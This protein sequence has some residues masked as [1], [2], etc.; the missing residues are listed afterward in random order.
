MTAPV[1]FSVITPTHRRPESLLRMLDG[2]SRQTYPAALFEVIVVGDGHLDEKVRHA[3]FPFRFHAVEQE[4]SGPAAA[5]NHA[6]QLAVEPYALFLDDDVIPDPALVAQHAGSHAEPMNV[7]I[8]PLLP[9]PLVKPAPWTRWEWRTLAEQYRSMRVGEWAPTPRQFY[10]GNASVATEDVRAVGGFNQDF[11][12][13]EDVELAWR[14]HDRG[15]RFVFNEKAA[16]EHLAQRSFKAWLAAAHDY[17]RTD[18]MLERT[19]TG[20]DLPGYVGR[21]FRGRHRFTRALARAVL[22]QPMAWHAVPVAGAAVSRA[23]AAVGLRE[24]SMQ[25]CSALFTSAYWRGVAGQLG[26]DQTLALLQP[27]R[28]AAT[29]ETVA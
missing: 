17:G 21:E 19:R 25:V 9:A 15:L 5:R 4:K 3:R 12:R 22:A 6:L 10:T 18:V 26:R 20:R 28:P 14:L 11:T 13:G 23:A 29:A 7:V 8:G 2:L 1:R 24:A 16:A 27:G